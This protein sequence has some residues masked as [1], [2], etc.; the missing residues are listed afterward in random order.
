MLNEELLAAWLQLTNTIDNQRL[1]DGLSHNEAL[2]CGLLAGGCLTPSDL[3]AETHILK[4]QMTGILKS[5]EAKGVLRRQRSLKD[6]RRVELHL[7][8]KGFAR[9]ADNHRHA[10]ALADRIIDIMGEEK[11]RTLLL[12]LRQIIEFFDNIQ[13]EV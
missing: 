11:I 4:P 12:L 3:C 13:A 7:L 8:P 1:A 5:L 9:Y 10:L 6:G 2:V